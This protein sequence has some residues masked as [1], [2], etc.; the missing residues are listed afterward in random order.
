MHYLPEFLTVA[1]LHLLAVMSPGPDFFMISR[2]SLIYSRRTGI[3]S[4]LGLALGILVHVTYSI[5]GIG[6][7]ISKSIV[8]F[9]TIK[10]LGAGYLIYIGYKSFKSK[11]V[12]EQDIALQQKPP[13][14]TTFEAIKIG[15]LTN[16]LNPKAT[17]F[18]FSLFS[19]VI[20]TSTPIGI[21]V[22]YG[23]EMSIATFIWFAFLV[24]LFTH[25]RIKD[26]LSKF[27]HYVSKTMGLILIALGIKIALS[28]R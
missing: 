4:A 10:L 15:F 13:D 27:Q 9:S 17:L 14:L 2:N 25:S 8:L 7:I 11:P 24:L 12:H 28:R 23:I 6:L 26:R 16:V 21:K 3:L 19:Q 5:V 1:V 18:F 20:H 22:F